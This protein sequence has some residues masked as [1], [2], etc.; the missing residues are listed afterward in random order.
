YLVFVIWVFLSIQIFVFS[1]Q[2]IPND[3]QV[4]KDANTT[5]STVWAGILKYNKG[6]K[7]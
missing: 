5:V 2:S 3:E 4:E 1:E 7:T 6:E